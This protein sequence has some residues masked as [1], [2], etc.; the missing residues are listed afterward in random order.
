MT[1]VSTLEFNMKH[2]NS[3]LQ[4]IDISKVGKFVPKPK[5]SLCLS[6][7]QKLEDLKS[8]SNKSLLPASTFIKALYYF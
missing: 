8:P 4:K 2:K 1:N 7:S 3:K 6:T 5:S